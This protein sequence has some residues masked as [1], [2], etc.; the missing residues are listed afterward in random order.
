MAGF[1]HDSIVPDRTSERSKKEQVAGM[2][3]DIAHRYDFMNRFLS[4]GI[5]VG[6]RRKALRTLIPSSP[7]RILDVAT[8]T[9]EVAIMAAAM[10]KP[11]QILGIDI[12]EG[13]LEIGRS[14][15]DKAGLSEVIQLQTG[16]SEEIDAPD[17][18]FD[19][20]TVAFGVRNFA[21]LTRGLSE[22]RRVLRPGGRLVVLEFSKPRLPGIRSLYGWYMG[23]VAPGMGSLFTRNPAAYR[24]LNDSVRNFPEGHA[25][26]EV[27]QTVG[28]RE[29]SCKRLS[30]G[31][32]SVYSASK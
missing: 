19:A 25:F 27:L 13:M 22:I 9:A 28:F 6:W 17:D 24:Y 12:S 23:R 10:L 2:F 7:R 15:V 5:D 21:D 14:K 32:C 26:L 18:S 20:V 31:I 16:D 30:L 1:A 4:A 11:E 3:D 8:G 29:T